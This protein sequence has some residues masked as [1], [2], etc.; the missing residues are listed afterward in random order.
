M[1]RNSKLADKLLFI[2]F[3]IIPLIIVPLGGAHDHFYQP[4]AIAFTLVAVLFI[5][6]IFIDR[7]NLHN[8]VSLDI[9]NKALLIYF[10]LIT[11]SIFFA[12]DFRRAIEGRVYRNE[13]YSTL[14]AYFVILL[15]A[16]YAGKVKRRVFIGALA[17]SSI[18][19]AYA[20]MQY[21]GFDPVPRDIFRTSWG[22][23]AFSTMGN[24]NFL[25]SYLVLTLP[26][27]YHLF[28][29]R[30]KSLALIPLGIIFYA[31]LASGTR[32]SWIGMLVS[33]VVYSWISI[34]SSEEKKVTV[35]GWQL[36]WH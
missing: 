22:A 25:G 33:L 4:K 11:V 26:F 36:F 6:I 18:V 24:P 31:M 23:R 10:S 17:A 20:L 9:A 34:K 32:S 7:K 28:V 35:K 5:F 14:L 16:R 1:D 2:L 15:L 12:E 3:F 27:A 19:S 13:G 8:Y 29:K 21:Y 30:S